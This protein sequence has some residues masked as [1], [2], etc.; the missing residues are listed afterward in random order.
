VKYLNITTGWEKISVGIDGLNPKIPQ[1]MADTLP[2]ITTVEKNKYFL[3]IK[4]NG[5]LKGYCIN[6]GA[7]ISMT[8]NS[9]YSEVVLKDQ[10]LY[11]FI[12]AALYLFSSYIHLKNN[13]CLI[14]SAGISVGKDGIIFAGASGAGKTTLAKKFGLL[15]VLS[16]EAVSI[17][18]IK[19]EY[20]MIRTPF[21]SRE[22][23][24]VSTPTKVKAIFLQTKAKKTAF[25]DCPYPYS[26]SQ[27]I[28]HIP[29]LHLMPDEIKKKGFLFINGLCKKVDTIMTA[30][31]TLKT[32]TFSILKKLGI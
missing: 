29:Y 9:N 12:F 14:H 32:K 25:R 26:V 27:I 30:E 6:P 22:M 18:K 20:W 1:Y 28:P 23:N 3:T 7:K 5:K 15:N 24:Y 11:P 4:K 16:D 8:L 2:F 17:K 13:A 21:G 10:H 31:L 19:N